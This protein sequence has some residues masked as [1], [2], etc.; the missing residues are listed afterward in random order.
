MIRGG[1]L[2]GAAAALIAAGGLFAM[3]SLPADAQGAKREVPLDTKDDASARPWKRY[4]GWPSLC[5]DWS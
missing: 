5:F 3:G 4:P 1:I 2:A